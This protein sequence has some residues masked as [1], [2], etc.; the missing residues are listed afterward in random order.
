MAA[1]AWNEDTPET[2]V[3]TPAHTHLTAVIVRAAISG[4]QAG[5]QAEQAT[6]T[7][8][9]AGVMDR[10]S[11]TERPASLRHTPSTD[12]IPPLWRTPTYLL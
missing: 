12:D 3:T 7:A 11:T 6:G 10:E 1:S 8:P 4:R 5:R 9:G 2:V